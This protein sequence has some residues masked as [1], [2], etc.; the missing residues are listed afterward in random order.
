VD[1]PTNEG[2]EDR[3]IN[4]DMRT[5]LDMISNPTSHVNWRIFRSHGRQLF[6]VNANREPAERVMGVDL[7]YFNHSRN[8]LILV[9]YKKLD[10]AQN[11]RYRPDGDSNLNK[12][13]SRMRALDRYVDSLRKE[14]DEFRLLPS[15]SWIKL[16]HPLPYIPNSADMIHGMYLARSHFEQLRDDDRLKGPRG[17]VN[18]SYRTVPNYL[19][20]TTFSRFGGDRDDRHLW[21]VNTV[22]TSTDYP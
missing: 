19:D 12:E 9:Q 3:L 22:S 1:Y 2:H 7:I 17:G 10:A 13:L 11:G 18:F 16:C 15:P 6:I 21:N 4:Q 5:M 14:G 20:N 8:S